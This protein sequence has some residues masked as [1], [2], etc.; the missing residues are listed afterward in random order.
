MVRVTVGFYNVTCEISEPI[1]PLTCMFSFTSW[2]YL[3]A[4]YR[5]PL[6]VPLQ[7]PIR[8]TLLQT[9]RSRMSSIVAPRH[10]MPYNENQDI[11]VEMADDQR[12][13]QMRCALWSHVQTRLHRRVVEFVWTLP[14]ITVNHT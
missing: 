8:R 2:P 7:Q 6:D 3:N 5:T 1:L 10:S 13:I 14:A 12:V 4:D 11:T 9:W